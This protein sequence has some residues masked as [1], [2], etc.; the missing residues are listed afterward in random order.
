MNLEPELDPLLPGPPLEN[1]DHA[2]AVEVADDDVGEASAGDGMRE[3]PRRLWSL[4]AAGGGVGRFRRLGGVGDRGLEGVAVGS[5][6]AVGGSFGFRR[7]VV[8]VEAEARGGILDGLDA[9]EE[10]VVHD[11]E[12][13]EEGRVGV[14]LAYDAEGLVRREAEA[15][16][17]IQI[18]VLEGHVG[19]VLAAD[20]RG[21]EG[22][23]VG[24]VLRLLGGVLHQAG[25]GPPRV[26]VVVVVVVRV[27]VG[28][29]APG[30]R[31][32]GLAEAAEGFVRVVALAAAESAGPADGGVGPGVELAAAAVAPEANAAAAGGSAALGE[33]LPPGAEGKVVP[34]RGGVG[35]LAVAVAAGD[36][37]A[38]PR[39]DHGSVDPAALD[40]EA[41]LGHR[42]GPRSHRLVV[43]GA[44]EG[45]PDAAH[46]VLRIGPQDVLHH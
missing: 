40:V 38:G 39:R 13:G 11:A 26:V 34:R 8:V 22:I 35:V 30:R 25:L 24:V 31:G 17:V 46:E 32:R 27:E 37:L 5:Q 1:V 16:G 42:R 10:G 21:A 19:L 20:G 14:E 44:R 7:G 15:L 29:P 6:M 12:G 23:V 18:V 33:G 36:A 2:E 28:R 41:G 45:V 4:V 3:V 9:E 43:A